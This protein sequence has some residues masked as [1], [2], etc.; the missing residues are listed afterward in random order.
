MY[1]MG[2]AADAAFDKGCGDHGEGRPLGVCSAGVY[3]SGHAIV[4]AGGREGSPQPS[5]ALNAWPGFGR[6][7][8]ISHPPPAIRN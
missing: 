7:L 3:C 4:A 2:G 6:L 5:A 8:S 1:R